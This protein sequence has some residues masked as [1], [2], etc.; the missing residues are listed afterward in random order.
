MPNIRANSHAPECGSPAAKWKSPGFVGSEEG[1][2]AAF[3]GQSQT[4]TQRQRGPTNPVFD[5]VAVG[6][7]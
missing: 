6:P 7:M 3:E 5:D 2:A 1:L 4:I